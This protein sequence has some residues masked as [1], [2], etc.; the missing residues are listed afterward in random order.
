MNDIYRCQV[1]LLIRVMPLVFSLYG[2]KAQML[3]SGN[4]NG[5]R[6]N[7]I[8]TYWMRYNREVILYICTVWRVSIQKR[9]LS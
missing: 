5:I 3:N 7:L 4:G 6:C 8:L 9:W 1:A 2:R